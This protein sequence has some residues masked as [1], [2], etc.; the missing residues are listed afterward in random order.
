M[1]VRAPD[2][3]RPRLEVQGWGDTAEPS[4]KANDLERRREMGQFF[5]PPLVATFMWDMLEIIHGAKFPGQTRVIDPACGEGVF[6]RVAAERGQIAP[7]C[8]FGADIDDTLS[9][10]WRRGALLQHAHLLLANG[11]LDVPSHGLTA[12][13]FDLVVGNPPFAG[14][15][16]RDL[17]RLLDEPA[18]APAAAEPTLFAE[19][20]V[21]ERAT[22][23]APRLTAQG[24][25]A[26][27]QMAREL[28]RYVC[29]RLS[30]EQ[31]GDAEAN[32]DAD[33]G[34][35]FANAGQRVDRRNGA[36]EFQRAADMAEGWPR[37]RL[38]DPKRAETKL[39][40]RRLASTA[41]EVF[42]ME[43]FLRLAKPGGLI[44]VIVPESIVASDQLGPLR[45]WLLTELDLLAVVSLPQKVFAGVGANAKTSVVFARRLLSPRADV[46][47]VDDAEDEADERKVLLAALN[48]DSPGYGLERYLADVC[49]TARE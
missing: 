29:W 9:P 5:T 33:T 44:G 8:L 15:G 42:F 20:V 2:R 39:L 12:G 3:R 41:I 14:K 47:P 25:A 27:D 18:Y 37:D 13:S 23:S 28:G 17:L 40:I 49:Q 10:G 34:Q 35:L 11:L 21:R 1:P 46:A 31:N 43:R 30:K 45:T 16:V 36:S 22:P 26:L 38:L 6:L 19:M 4:V 32:G 24:R 48:A 7:D